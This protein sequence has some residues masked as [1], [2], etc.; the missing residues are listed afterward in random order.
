MSMNVLSVAAMPLF[1]IALALGLVVWK[2]TSRTR[3]ADYDPAWLEEFSIAKYRPMLRLLSEDDYEFLA[4]Q[5]GYQGKIASQLRAERRKVFRAYLRNLVRDF[6]RLHHVAKMMAVYSIQD[7]PEFATALLKQRI[8]FSVAVTG[9]RARLVLH[10]VG[11]GAVDV[12]NLIETL[13]QMR[14]NVNTLIPQANS[15]A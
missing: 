3:P 9:V 4:S 14:S 13:D 15:A 12:R 11:I 10:T 6:H 1:F 5:A 8:V 2:M 7:R